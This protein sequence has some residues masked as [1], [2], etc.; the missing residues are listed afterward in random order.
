MKPSVPN[1]LGTSVIDTELSVMTAPH[2][3]VVTGFFILRTLYR[4][5]VGV[6]AS[7]VNLLRPM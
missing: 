4:R 2:G 1:D 7:E 5:Y 3:L 6:D